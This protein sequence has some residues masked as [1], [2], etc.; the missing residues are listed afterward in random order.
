MALAVTSMASL[1]LGRELLWGRGVF[2]VVG[3]LNDLDDN[4]L[5]MVY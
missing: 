4:G 3:G 2:F 1:R 5:L